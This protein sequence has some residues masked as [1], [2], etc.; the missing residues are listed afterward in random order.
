MLWWGLILVFSTG[1]LLGV[2]IA[3]YLRVR[4]HMKAAG[5]ATERDKD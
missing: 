5:E 3:L 4:H 1:A 2:G